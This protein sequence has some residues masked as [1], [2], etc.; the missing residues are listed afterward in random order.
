M[1]DHEDKTSY[2]Q[3]DSL[4]L[5]GAITLGTGV[6]VADKVEVHFSTVSPDASLTGF[7]GVTTLGIL[8]IT[9]HKKVAGKWTFKQRLTVLV[10][11]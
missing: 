8:A 5:V 7:I 1:N 4:T 9:R 3:K 6:M 2:Y 11:C 10:L